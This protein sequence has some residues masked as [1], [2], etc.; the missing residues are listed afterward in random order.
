MIE[1]INKAG[2]IYIWG[3]ADMGKNALEYCRNGF[4][5]AGFID[6]RANSGFHEFCSKQVMAP[7]LFFAKDTGEKINIIIAVRY[8]IE[9]INWIM[10]ETDYS[11]ISIYIFDGR[12]SGNPLLY[13]VQN[14][15][16]CVPEYMNKRFKEWK[17]Y[18]VHYS[19]LNP[20]ILK[21]F[22]TALDWIDEYGKE[23]RICELGC[24]SGQFANMLFDH[25]Y[26]EYTG[27]DFSSQAIELAKKANSCYADQFVCE[28][29]F[30]YLWKEKNKDSL[31]VL[32]EILEHINKDVELC[33][34]IPKGSIIIFSV[35]NFKSFNHVHTFANLDS[36]QSKYKMFHIEK[37]L[38][39]P[40]SANADKRYHLVK[41]TKI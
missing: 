2:K 17:E 38:S 24:G 12:N 6:K 30:S 13:E 28:N 29:V 32:F 33:N 34:R 31:F 5:I 9:V 41:A 19:K 37:Y 8:P 18:A 3:A 15:E 40:A 1:Q 25:G 35:P 27:I 26:M 10:Q 39:L 14:G 21:M 20:F 22:Q 7:S 11:H 16:I 23:T 36:V 4:T